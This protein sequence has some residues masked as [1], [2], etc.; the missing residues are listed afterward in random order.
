VAGRPAP[1]GDPLSS[2]N[3]KAADHRFGSTR[4]PIVGL[5][6]V[7]LVEP[8][9]LVSRPQRSIGRS[10]AAVEVVA[11]YSL[12]GRR[13]EP[14]HE[15]LVDPDLRAAADRLRLPAGSL[16]FLIPECRMPIGLPDLLVASLDQAAVLR[17]L[18]VGAPP[19]LSEPAM[20]VAAHLSATRPTMVDSLTASLGSTKRQGRRALLGL[21]KLGAVRREGD[22]WFRAAGFEPVGRTYAL[23][24]K[25]DDWRSGLD[26][27]LRYGAYVDS[28]TLVLPRMSEKVRMTAVD[29][30]SA[31]GVGL[32]VGGKWLVRPRLSKL[33]G[34]KR[35]LASE[36]VLA[37][38]GD[39]VTLSSPK[40]N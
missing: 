20:R 29:R 40:R 36:Y 32:F 37:A 6:R 39:T 7:G 35:L 1:P 17:R 4:C 30:F 22:Q 26:Q 15:R 11:A 10:Q 38:L 34:A 23:E 3:G 8:R 28:T 16:N 31:L 18:A 33:K 12:G 19:I 9:D 2:L 27:C 24:A 14:V 13:F 21:A 25:V 5:S